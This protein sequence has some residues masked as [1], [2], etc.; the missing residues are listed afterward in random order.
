MVSCVLFGLNT[1]KILLGAVA[2]YVGDHNRSRERPLF[3][4]VLWGSWGGEER[5]V[6]F[7]VLPCSQAASA[8]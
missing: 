3:G 5:D 8:L 6:L 2:V 1:I 7:F 4:N